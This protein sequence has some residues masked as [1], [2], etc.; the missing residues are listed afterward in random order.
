MPGW[1]F[2]FGVQYNKIRI[3]FGQAVVWDKGDAKPDTGK[4]D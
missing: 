3:P 1:D 2:F 4:V